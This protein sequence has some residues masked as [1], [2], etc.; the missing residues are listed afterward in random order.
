MPACPK[1]NQQIDH[2]NVMVT[3]RNLYTYDGT[4]DYERRDSIEFDIDYWKCPLCH[5]QLDLFPN[6]DTADE[7]L[8]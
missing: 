4:G 6:S 7:F 1:C 3:E 8:S 2:L 5:A